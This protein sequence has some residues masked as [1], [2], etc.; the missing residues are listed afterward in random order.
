VAARI[1]LPHVRSAAKLPVEMTWRGPSPNQWKP[2]GGLGCR[3]PG[4]GASA[5]P[6]PDP[7]PAPSLPM[8]RAPG[9]QNRTPG[10]PQARGLLS[11]LS[12][13]LAGYAPAAFDYALAHPLAT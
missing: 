12:R 10:P 4:G 13:R 5:A 7:L 11:G 2:R 8:S 6:P 1:E 9:V 3:L